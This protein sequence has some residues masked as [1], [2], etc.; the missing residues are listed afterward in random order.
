MTHA[1]WLARVRK[2]LAM[3]ERQPVRALASLHKIARQ[4]HS[5]SKKTTGDWHIEQTLQVISIVQS[6]QDDHH[7]SAETI[8]A[9][10]DRHEQQ[11]SYYSRGFVAACATAALEFASA[12][13][14]KA[15]WR[16][17]QRARPVSIGLRPPER[18]FRKAEKFVSAMPRR[19]AGAHRVQRRTTSRRRRRL[20]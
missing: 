4:L 8:L 6:H 19:P 2:S 10:A 7:R 18:L 1:Q 9:V 14:R 20:S 16:A 15:A 13:D 3:V 12:G 5:E 17:L 11:M